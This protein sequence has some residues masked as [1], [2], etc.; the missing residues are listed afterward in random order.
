MPT[1]KEA[2]EA[3]ERLREENGVTPV[4]DEWYA[5]LRQFIEEAGRDAERYRW[6]RS[7]TGQSSRG[8]ENTAPVAFMV[9]PAFKVSAVGMDLDAAIDAARASQPQEKP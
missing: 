5:T 9:L 1:T 7:I 2:M 6:I 3:L 8:L 4:E